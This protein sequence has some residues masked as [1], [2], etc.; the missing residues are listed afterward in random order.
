MIEKGAIQAVAPCKGEFISTLF[1]V[2]KKSGGFRP[3]INLKPLN[4]FVEKI[5]FKMENIQTAIESL[6]Y[7]DYMVSLDLKDAYFS[8]PIFPPHRKYLRF[9]WNNIRYE[10]TCLPFGYSL[11]P[12]V[13]TKIFKPILASLR[14]KGIR[15][16]IFIDDILIIAESITVCKQHLRMVRELLESLGFII[17]VNKSSLIPSTRITFLGFELDSIAMKVFLPQGKVL[18]IIQACDQL[19]EM[20]NPTLRQI[21]HVTGLIVSAFPAIRYLQLHYR[22]IESCKSEPISLGQDYDDHVV[23]DEQAKDDLLWV[24]VNIMRF[25][26]K[27]VS[28]P[29]IDVYIG[30]DASLS[31]WGATCLN[32]NSGGRWTSSESSQHINYLELLAAFFALQSFVSHRRSIHVRIQL[33]S[34]SAV[35]YINNMG[36]I[37]SNLLNSLSVEIWSWC[38]ARDIWL[39]AQHIPGVQ[40]ARADFQSRVFSDD[41][42]WSLHPSIF[43]RIVGFTYTPNVDL[44]ASR[45]NHKVHS[46]VSWHPDPRAVATD[47]FAISWSN[48]KC[49]AFP[50]FSLIP[51]VLS[52]IQRDKASVL[53]IAPVWPTQ[54]WYPTLLQL[55]VEQPI[56]L[57]RWNNLLV[58]P[59]NKQLHPLRNKL[60]LAAWT[61]SGDPLQAEVFLNKQSTL[62]V[63]VGRLGQKNN[64]EQFGKS[65]LAGVIR[66]TL[67]HFRHLLKK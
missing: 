19:R 1:L 15:L 55:L 61:V 13:F 26:G 36:G 17:N 59:H 20:D 22:S 14:F 16:I 56:L 24:S 4:Q 42:E 41:L 27:P 49:Y 8:V 25:N 51:R 10:F 54:G 29:S 53:L 67:I 64:T 58:L 46:Y 37:K 33:D 3:V 38:I 11:A 60:L 48:Q 66:G 7:G 2:P 32:Q 50:P 34:S 63:P 30:S 28:E 21:A 6:N 52:K 44:F 39:S 43:Q 31:G 9:L 40:N 65:G 45:L 57:P 18:K 12:R 35:A 47:A 5:H 62:C 23:L